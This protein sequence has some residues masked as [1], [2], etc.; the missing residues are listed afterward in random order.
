MDHSNKEDRPVRKSPIH[1]S[2]EQA[3]PKPKGI[4]KKHREPARKK[5]IVWDE[6]NLAETESQKS[7]TMKIDE[8]KTP[9][10]YYDSSGE[11]DEESAASRALQL[12]DAVGKLFPK[13]SIATTYDS[14]S[15]GKESGDGGTEGTESDEG[16]KDDKGGSF[17]PET[18]NLNTSNWG[19]MWRD[20]SSD[21]S[22]KDS[23]DPETRR[24][25]AEKRKGHYN[26]FQI[27][28]GLQE[29]MKLKRNKHPSGDDE[30]DDDVEGEGEKEGNG[31]IT[32]TTTTS[33]QP[34]TSTTTTTTSTTFQPNN[35][36]SHSDITNTKNSDSQQKHP[37]VS[38]SANEGNDIEMEDSD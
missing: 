1:F 37:P 20:S 3:H 29:R 19:V 22:G 27:L 14:D 7:A 11:E 34:L 35:P 26:E 2:N 36:S 15:S 4:L 38:T 25:F 33:S 24:K 31:L 10:N 6:Q 9:Y 16:T 21:E 17:K 32:C 23:K 8:P 12:E 28:K 13:T 18:K 5:R 30:E